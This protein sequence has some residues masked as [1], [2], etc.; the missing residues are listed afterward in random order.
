MLLFAAIIFYAGIN[1]GLNSKKSTQLNSQFW[2]KAY[3]SY[4]SET[5]FAV[6]AAESTAPLFTNQSDLSDIIINFEAPPD[7][8]EGETNPDSIFVSDTLKTPTDS[9]VDP[10]TLIEDTVKV[11]SMALDSTGRLEHFRYQREDVPYVQIKERKR[12]KFFVEPSQTFK[13]KKVTIDS[14]GNF[15]EIREI[16]G[17]KDSKILLRVP[18]E[19]YVQEK[20]RLRERK[21]WEEIGYKYELKDSKVG[22]GDLIKSI[23]DFEIPLPSVGILTIFGEPKISLRIGGQVQIR[24]AWRNETTEGVTASRLGNTRNEPDFKQQVQINVN[25]T[26]GDK[27][28][29]AADWNT[30]RTFEY[31]NQ[32]KIKYTGYDDEIIQSIEAGNVTLQTSPLIGGSEALFGLKAQFKMGP[33]TLTTLASQKKGETKEVT[34]S[35]GTTSQEFQIRAYDYSTNHYFL[36]TLYASTIP[37]LDLFNRYYGSPTPEIDNNYFVKDIQVWK[38]INVINIDKSK[39]RDANAYINLT[40]I[41][42]NGAYDENL[43]NDIENPSPG[44]EESGR[45]LLLTPDV[46]YTLQPETGFI[47]F[48]TAINEID[49][50]A[51][52]YRTENGPGNDN[53]LIFGEFLTPADTNLSKRL[54]LKLIKPKNLQPDYQTAWK[55]QLKNIYPVGARNI[56][57]DGFEFDINYEIDGSEAVSEVQGSAGLVRFLNAFGFDNTGSSGQGDPDNKFDYRPGITIFPATGEILFPNLQPFAKN[58]PDGLTDNFR[59]D[60]IYTTSKT[61]AR[62]DKVND[63]WILV[64]KSSGDASSTYQLGFNVVENSVRVLL[65]GRELTSKVDY[66]VDYNIGTLTI[67]NDAALVPGA[68]LRITYEQNDLFQLASK[69]LLGARGIYEF[70]KKTKLGFSILN[71]NQ[72]TLSDKVRI[73]EEP[74]SNTIYGLDF[75]TQADIPI[76]TK[77]IDNIFSTREM[78]SFTLSGEYAYIDP[79]PNTKK[80]TVLSDGGKSIAYI[81]D[82]EGAKRIIPIGVS[83]TSWR[84]LSPPDSLTY[85]P[86]LSRLEKMDHKGKTFWFTRTPSDITV[87]QIYGDRKQV[88]RSDQQVSVMDFVFMP[89]TPGTSNYTPELSNPN[90]SWGGNMK[91]L[92]STASNLVEENIEFIE[93]WLNI[94]KAP[95]STKLYID[96]GRIS[97]DA[98]PNNRLNTE[99][100]YN[101]ETITDPDVQDLGL[102]MLT[103]A[104]EK[105][106]Y[107]SAKADPAGDNFFFQRNDALHP[108]DYFNINGS[109]GNAILTDIGLIPDTEDLNRNGTLDQVNSYY[110]YEIPLDTNQGVNPFIAGGGLTQYGWYLYRIPLKDFAMQIGNP[111]FT[112][113]EFIRMFTQN[114]PE[115]MWFQITEF[116]LVGSQWQKLVAEDTILSVSVVSLEENPEYQSPPGVF[117]ERDRTRPDENILRNEQSLN[118]I[119]KDLPEGESREAVK[120]LFRPLDVFNYREMKLFIHGD[121]N[122]GPGSV[123]YTDISTGRYSAEVYFRFGGDTNH[124][125]EYRQPVDAGWNEISIIFSEL[126]AIKQLARDSISQI[127]EVPVPGRPGHFYRLKG[128]PTLTSVKFLSVGIYNLNDDF[129]PGLISGEV[130][131]NELRVIGADDS[132]GW[133]YSFNTSIKLADLMTVNFNMSERNPYFHRLQDRFGSRVESANW[134]IASDVNLLKLI[135]INLPESNLRLSYSHTEQVGKPLY[136]PGSDI[137]VDEAVK[138]L[139]LQNSVDSTKTDKTGEVLRTETQTL[140]VSDSWSASN[141]KIKIPTKWWLIRDSFNALTFGFN[142][143]KN[144]SR[145]PTTMV[146]KSWVWNA[147]I[148]YAVALSPDYYFEPIDIPVLGILFTLLTDYSKTKVYFTPQ[149]VNAS[150]TARRNKSSSIMRPTLVGGKLTEPAEA[151]SRDFQTTRGFNFNWKIT[152]GGFLNLSTNYNLNISSSLAYLETDEL[153]VP[154]TESQIWNDIFSRVFF[155]NDFRYQQNMD[156]RT[157]P[158]LPSLW[159]INRY[160]TITANYSVGYQWNNDFRQ[161][162]LG[163]SAGFSNKSSASLTLRLKALFDPLFQDEIDQKTSQTNQRVTGQERMIENIPKKED[164]QNIITT[165]TDSLGNVI[166]DSTQLADDKPGTLSKAWGFFKLAIKTILFDYENINISFSNDNSLSKSGLKSSGTGFANFWGFAHNDDEG[167]GRGFMLGLSDDVGPRALQKGTNLSDVFQH[168]NNFDFKTSR[169]LWEGAKID[170]NWKVGWSLN[171]NTTITADDFGNM[172]V[173]NINSSGTL[174]RSFLSLPPSLFL[175]VFNSGIKKVNELYNPNSQEAEASLSDA[176]IK[177]FETFPIFSRLAFLEEFTKYIPRPNWRVSWDGLEKIS[178]FQSIAT[179]VSLEHAYSSNYTEGWKL[180]PDGNKQVQTQKIDYAFSP[181][182][183]INLTFGQLWGGNLMGSIKYSTRTSYDLGITTSNITE[184][185]S[186]DIGFTVNYSKSGFE[187]PLFGVSLK[188]DIEFSLSYTS[189]KNSTVRYEM[190]NFTEEGIP[191]DGTARVTIEPRIKYTISS[192]VTLSVFYKRST[193]EPEG[194]SRIPPT[195]TNEAGLDVNIIIN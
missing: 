21:L 105:S 107:G 20:I 127:I 130:W 55:L 140:N 39:E 132:P 111:S 32:L 75:S 46:D 19:E 145:N 58:L 192:K 78:S 60:S 84:D 115:W 104:E 45:F 156:F 9:L 184:T 112:N 103:D 113:I 194:A 188:N 190:A 128:N 133:A 150:L 25:G 159:N 174:S 122:N 166:S 154:R 179:R 5:D 74:L 68:D 186:R 11:D 175:S 146:S 181:L 36:D 95:D 126:T 38:S 54:I 62:Q 66:S 10:F 170:I 52:A 72:Q 148:N 149:N 101:N 160:F 191:Q 165:K 31:E 18:I 47:T 12:S 193:V 51:V 142:Y 169:P 96:L 53:D 6:N 79:D 155:G 129:N 135:P 139:K 195:T 57:P 152:E 167:P 136:I 118:L 119:I 35:S 99:D 28:N 116:N 1:V 110:R 178:F 100:I 37:G 114:V 189:A 70:S 13:Q 29:I 44:E 173:S 64:G 81:D 187:L 164:P 183:G 138:Q 26:I 151:I 56:K 16:L 22:L 73:G 163:K 69:T 24:G 172:I 2:L 4:L 89:D 61:F 91:V 125:Y 7:T 40:S 8:G 117:Q 14:T 65:N 153:G 97:E 71:L 33:F 109:Q 131:V 42:L 185:F 27:L 176:F 67:R 59:Y 180:S 141:I 23:T 123:S 86:G 137:R 144:F 158:K 15:V 48:K 93:F 34:V 49:I 108:F 94:R 87:E 77:A 98:I 92:S 147:N 76:V 168:K 83:Y 157:S 80:S 161:P 106:L 143:N 182:A 82:F 50:I 17:G 3:L 121:G 63:K 124:Y 102:D 177:G 134:S 171:K 41:P 90:T 30:E 88:A 120:Y 162:E 43:R 85:L